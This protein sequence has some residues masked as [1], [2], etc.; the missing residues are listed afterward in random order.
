MKYT[1]FVRGPLPNIPSRSAVNWFVK[2]EAGGAAFLT[3]PPALALF[4]AF[5]ETVVLAK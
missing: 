2:I 3:T 4:G 5:L 1:T